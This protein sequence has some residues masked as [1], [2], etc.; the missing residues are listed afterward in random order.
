M[1]FES[2]L[3]TKGKD[4]FYIMHLS[5][6]GHN[7]EPLWD[8]SKENKVIGLDLPNVV[9]DDWNK[10]KESVR[11]RISGIWEKQFEI[12]CNEMKTGDI[13]MILAGWDSILGVADVQD[14]E[15]QYNRELRLRD[16]FFD[17][18][19]KV[20]WL[21]ENNFDERLRLR[22][23]VNGFNNTLHKV[24]KDTKWWTNLVETYIQI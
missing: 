18:F 15:Y 9:K 2:L 14:D 19:R 8:Y 21:K 1:K 16:I 4:Y 22:Y 17:H 20:H 5:Y 6:S 12:F 3:D 7:R 10:V 24:E 13:V 11:E 23:P